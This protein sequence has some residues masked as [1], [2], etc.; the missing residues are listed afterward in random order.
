MS[1]FM[2]ISLRIWSNGLGLVITNAGKKEKLSVDKLY[3]KLDSALRALGTLNLS[4]AHP[5]MYFYPLV[6]SSLPED[7]LR[8]WQ[9]SPMSKDD[10]GTSEKLA[11]LMKFL[12]TEAQGEQQ[13]ALARSGFSDEPQKKQDSKKKASTSRQE[14]D[15]PTAAG[16]HEAKVRDKECI[17]CG[18]SNHSSADCYRA[19]SMPPEERRSKVRESRACFVCLRKGHAAKVC[20]A[21]VK[22]K[23]C[24]KRHYAL[25]C[26]ELSHQR[27]SPDNRN[28]QAVNQASTETSSYQSSIQCDGEVLLKT[29]L[30]R[31]RHQNK[32][33]TVRLL[34]DEGSQ[35]SYVTSYTCNGIRSKPVGE[36][37]VRNVMID[38]SVTS[39]RRFNKHE[40]ELS[41]VD[42]KSKRKLL[43]RERPQIGGIPPRA[44]MGPWFQQL[45][46]EK[47]WISDHCQAPV[48]RAD[49][50]IL[51][52]GDYREQLMT[53]RRVDLK[54]GLFAIESVFG[55]MLCGPTCS[56]EQ[57][58]TEMVIHSYLSGDISQLWDLETIGIKDSATKVSR[59]E[60]EIQ[61]KETFQKQVTRDEEGRYVVKLPWIQDE[62][63]STI[64]NNKSVCEKRLVSATRKL[65][66]QEKF[67]VYADIFEGWESEK[68]I[69]RVHHVNSVE[70]GHYL[71][72][73]P[74]FKPESLTTPVRPVFDASCRM[75]NYPS[76]NQCLEKGPNMLELIP[77]ILLRFRE[78]KVG[79]ISDIRKAFQMIG[80]AEE[81]RKYQ[82]FLW[83]EEE[84]F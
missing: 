70:P 24:S 45:K 63:K 69:H 52:G 2:G 83:W 68:M 23:L 59:E 31:V 78:K 65:E 77:S 12:K 66:S 56:V 25:V 58:A 16:L 54:M 44:K 7:L 61:V 9:R 17:F 82:R 32:N 79:V 15:V 33:R 84:R 30:V 72:H 81:D 28:G 53:G 3:L 5:S 76:L 22:C 6:E 11:M 41:S 4:K 20:R 64:P 60:N 73:R 51:I 26:P 38:G 49:I 43:L 74:V 50:D 62:L 29:V 67:Q 40:M 1:K 48:E 36:E 42:G 21:V 75:A 8:A 55:W 47:I 39:P 19:H 34:F 10:D 35:K 14:E 13:I 57:S 80:V 37:V 27:G 71:P 46:R 18:K